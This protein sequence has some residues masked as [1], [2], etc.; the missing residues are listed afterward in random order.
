[1]AALFQTTSL[2]L[3]LAL[4]LG[5][6]PLL[7]PK[8]VHA[9]LFGDNETDE[10][11]EGAQKD[12]ESLLQIAQRPELPFHNSRA[13][14]LLS[15]VTLA[16]DNPGDITP[17]DMDGAEGAYW[18]FTLKKPLADAASY[19]YN[20]DVP[21]H[22]I[23]PGAVRMGGWL[24]PDVVAP[25]LKGLHTPLPDMENPVVARG[26]EF[27]ATTPDPNSGTYF[28]YDLDR[29]VAGYQNEQVPTII[30]VSRMRGESDIGKK[31]VAFGPPEDWY[32][33]YSGIKGNLLSGVGWAESKMYAS[34]SVI[35]F[36]QIAPNK[37]RVAIFKWVK[38]GWKGMNM[39]KRKH[40]LA[41]LK[42]YGRDLRDVLQAATLPPASAIAA[43]ADSIAKLDD[44]AMRQ[45][46]SPL[47]EMLQQNAATN[48]AL[49]RDEF[50]PL[51]Q[52]G[53]YLESLNREELNA[54]LVKDYMRRELSRAAIVA[55]SN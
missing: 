1:M 34:V 35:V 52:D 42:R 36:R 47:Q 44:A 28:R 31:G 27:E 15:F 33:F 53:G 32:F 12:V 20:A 45:K 24:Q 7:S 50:A 18:E 25:A 13:R 26:V 43:E 17:A 19:M 38:A 40:I 30:S 29:L 37:T 16:K 2:A 22:A 49:S 39:V 14:K 54:E 4:C 48:D 5:L 55:P 21:A 6:A 9:G 10:A 51:V 23:F 8:D 3:S 41:G 11:L 46:L